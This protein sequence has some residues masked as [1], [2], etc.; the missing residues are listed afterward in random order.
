VLSDYPRPVAAQPNNGLLGG[1]GPIKPGVPRYTRAVLSALLLSLLLATT[2]Q[3]ARVVTVHDGDTITVRIDGRTEKV[4]LIG[5]DSPEL[6]DERQAYRDAAH[7]ARNYARS[8]LGGETVTLETEPQQPDRDPYGRLLRY[9]ILD[10]GT[11]ANEEFVLK[12]Y[13]H[14]YDKFKFTLKPRFKAAES[15]AKREKLGVWKL[16]PGRWREVPSTR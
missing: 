3:T 5:I 6:D 11:N 9:V 2:P 8:R 4:R 16:P 7:A 14:V 1:N 13:A 10:D 12:G 15:E